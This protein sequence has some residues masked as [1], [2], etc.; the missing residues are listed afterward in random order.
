MNIIIDDKNILEYEIIED[1]KNFD[2]PY[3]YKKPEVFYQ[4]DEYSFIRIKNITEG[5][6]IDNVESKETETFFIDQHDDSNRDL[7]A[8]K[9]IDK[10]VKLLFTFI[11]G[12]RL[13]IYDE[14]KEEYQYAFYPPDQFV[15]LEHKGIYR[16]RI[17]K[18]FVFNS[19]EPFK[20]SDCGLITSRRGKIEYKEKN[21]IF[22]MPKFNVDVTITYFPYNKDDFAYIKVDLSNVH[23]YDYSY[24]KLSHNTN[25]SDFITTAQY[26]DDYDFGMYD[27]VIDE[28]K[29]YIFGRN[30][31][32][33]I[34]LSLLEK[35]NLK[36]LLNGKEI[37]SELHI[38]KYDGVQSFI[39]R[40]DFEDTEETEETKKTENQEDKVQTSNS[41]NN[42]NDPF[43][44]DFDD[45]FYDDGF[46]EVY[47]DIYEYDFKFIKLKESGTISFEV[48]E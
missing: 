44:D 26:S 40:E 41:E 37:N 46:D 35:V 7:I 12:Y 38:T 18:E 32:I 10:D 33:R 9:N 30:C 19:K 45:D 6:M 20:H 2:I 16:D 17:V 48:I 31:N 8:I 24:T 15:S 11:E 1:K 4:R 13:R 34:K 5:L 42:E 27:K 36:I 25:F 23:K 21:I 14:A 22:S 39:K 29:E 28:E 47:D 43:F 3:T